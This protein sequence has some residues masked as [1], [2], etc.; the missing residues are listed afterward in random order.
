MCNA[1]ANLNF[2][3]PFRKCIIFS[4]FRYFAF[5]YSSKMLLPK[6]LQYRISSNFLLFRRV[7]RPATVCGWVGGSIRGN[8]VHHRH[9]FSFPL[10]KAWICYHRVKDV[11]RI[12]C[13]TEKLREL[14]WAQC[15]FWAFYG[16]LSDDIRQEISVST[17]HAVIF[18][19]C[20]VFT[21]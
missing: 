1:L 15:K 7:R 5:Y 8:T 21:I 11:R 16:L 17:T 19:P 2:K 13:T 9:Q 12:K 6:L 14:I 20:G 18:W 3:N 10:L 4:F